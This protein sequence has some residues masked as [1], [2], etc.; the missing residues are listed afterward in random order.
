MRS[1]RRPLGKT[2]GD[3]ISE[4][5]EVLARVTV[6]LICGTPPGE[7]GGETTPKVVMARVMEMGKR[8]GLSFGEEDA[9]AIVSDEGELVDDT[10]GQPR[11]LDGR[12]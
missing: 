6:Q 1:N 12:G 2:V 5:L 10:D 11:K 7:W 4:E 3:I 9:H 8:L